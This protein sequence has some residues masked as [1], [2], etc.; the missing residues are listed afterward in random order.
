MWYH[1]L[2]PTRTCVHVDASQT[3]LGA[4]LT[5]DGKG[6]CICKQDAFFHR[7]PL[8][9]DRAGSSGNFMGLSPFQD[10]SIGETVLC[11]DRPQTTACNFNNLNSKA[12]ARIENWQ[13]C[14]QQFDFKVHFCQGS[15]NPTD[16]ISR[17][18]SHEGCGKVV[19]FLRVVK[20]PYVA[21]YRAMYPRHYP[22]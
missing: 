9:R 4:M 19:L 18:V 2:T 20:R 11:C 14:L 3:G 22:C 10:V 16:F 15:D 12:S 17:Y 8:F 13:L 7:M 1:I 21:W 6:Y 5:Q